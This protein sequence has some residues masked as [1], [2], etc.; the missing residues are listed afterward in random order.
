MR[1]NVHGVCDST[2]FVSV[3]MFQD[4]D[5]VIVVFDQTVVVSDA[6]L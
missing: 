6:L 5:D 1:A 2:N 4:D 3:S